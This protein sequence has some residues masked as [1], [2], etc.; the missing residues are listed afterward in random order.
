M[1]R[2][3]NVVGEGAPSLGD[4]GIEPTA[5]EVVV[6]TYLTPHRKTAEA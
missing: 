4:L 6:P 3:D 1:L 2:R 5:A